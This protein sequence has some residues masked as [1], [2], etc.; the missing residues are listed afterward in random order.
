MDK[1]IERLKDKV[2]KYADTSDAS[3]K[4]LEDIKEVIDGVFRNVKPEQLPGIYECLVKGMDE[5][6]VTRSLTEAFQL[7]VFDLLNDGQWPIVGDI[8]EWEAPGCGVRDGWDVGI[9]ITF[10]TKDSVLDDDW[11]E[12]EEDIE[13]DPNSIFD[14]YYTYYIRIGTDFGSDYSIQV[15]DLNPKIVEVKRDND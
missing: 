11:D 1:Y 4:R 15:F 13:D 2:L 8:Y 5:D 3:G 14:S 10:G 6:C 7:H 12:D 9:L